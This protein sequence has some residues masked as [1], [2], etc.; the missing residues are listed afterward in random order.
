MVNNVSGYTNTPYYNISGKYTGEKKISTALCTE[1]NSSIPSL[2]NIV[3][4][5]QADPVMD[6]YKEICSKY[7]DVSF[8]LDDQNAR[9]DYEK[10]NGT[11]CCPYLGYNNSS[12][13]VGDNFGKLSQ[14]SCRIDSSVLKRC[15]AD[16][17]YREEFEY[18]LNETLTG[19]DTWKQRALDMNHTNMCVGFTDEGGK[20]GIYA[21]GANDE[22]STDDE[23]KRRWGVGGSYN[24]LLQ[25]VESTNNELL[26]QFMELLSKH[27]QELKQR[28]LNDEYADAAIGTKSMSVQEKRKIIDEF[29][30]SMDSIQ[31]MDN[32][33]LQRRIAILLEA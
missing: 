9:S 11:R 33:E 22:F 18:Y 20:L 8:R 3:K 16:P 32:D 21:D 29:E 15:L 17:T 19:Y 24:E 6:L 26:D 14:K 13:Q 23:I 31:Q 10:K 30:S 5:E 1:E 27:T 25:K 7:S 12:N 2:N 4:D 28:L